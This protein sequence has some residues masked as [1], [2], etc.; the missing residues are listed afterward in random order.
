[1]LE[2]HEEVVQG[3]VVAQLAFDLGHEDELRKALASTLAQARA[4]VTRELTDLQEAGHP[5][6]ELI[7]DAASSRNV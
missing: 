1:V 4:M 6:D 7:G 2:L 5:L 3:L